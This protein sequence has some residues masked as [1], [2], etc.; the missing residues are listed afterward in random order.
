[1]PPPTAAGMPATSA[2]LRAKA[3][4]AGAAAVAVVT[5]QYRHDDV[6]ERYEDERANFRQAYIGVLGKFN[7][8]AHVDVAVYEGA[9]W[10]NFSKDVVGLAQM[11][12]ALPLHT[13]ISYMALLDKHMFARVLQEAP[14]TS[15]G[16]HIL[17]AGDEISASTPYRR[18]HA[19][20]VDE[21]LSRH[22]RTA[23]DAQALL[24]AHRRQSQLAQLCAAA[25]EMPPVELATR[26]R[27]LLAQVDKVVAEEEK[28]ARL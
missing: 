13:A 7:A 21:S 23:H 5:A 6:P 8:Q 17:S 24:E 15:N 9:D 18:A 12:V 27:L 16:E 3:T 11:L 14:L 26:L 28:E 2:Q 4:R 25:D 20:V 19:Y 22:L 1:M 10:F